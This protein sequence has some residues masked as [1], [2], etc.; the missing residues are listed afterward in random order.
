MKTVMVSL[1][2]T[3]VVSDNHPG[4]CVHHRVFY[5]LEG[6]GHPFVREEAKEHGSGERNESFLTSQFLQQRLAKWMG[7][8]AFCRRKEG[9]NAHGARASKKGLM[10]VWLLLFDIVDVYTYE[11]SFVRFF[12]GLW[13]E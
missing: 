4:N 5:F 10:G 11:P 3:L 1:I 8:L 9:G 6:P 7:S 12:E 13:Q 2:F